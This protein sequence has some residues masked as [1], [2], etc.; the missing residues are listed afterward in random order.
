MADEEL[1]ETLAAPSGLSAVAP[2]PGGPVNADLP[3][4]ITGWD[5]AAGSFSGEYRPTQNGGPVSFP[6]ALLTG[7]RPAD[8]PEVPVPLPEPN[9]PPIIEN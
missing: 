4:V 2:L 3:V 8:V 1:N 6:T 9:N 7:I 5:Q